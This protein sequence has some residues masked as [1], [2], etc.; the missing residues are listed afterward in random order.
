MMKA[1]DGLAVVIVIQLTQSALRRPA[2]IRA[3]LDLRPPMY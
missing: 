2:R 1:Y 3:K